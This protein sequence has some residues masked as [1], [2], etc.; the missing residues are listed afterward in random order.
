MD[1]MITK[2]FWIVFL[3][4]MSMYMAT[5]SSTTNLITVCDCTKPKTKGLIDL[6]IPPYCDHAHSYTHTKPENTKYTIVSKNRPPYYFRGYLCE[7]WIKE[8]KIIG[9]F[10]I[11][12]FNTEYQ[13]YS[14]EVS[15]DECWKMVTELKCGDASEPNMIQAVKGSNEAFKR[16]KEPDGPGKWF[17]EITY[18]ETNFEFRK[19]DLRQ[20]QNENQTFTKSFTLTDWFNT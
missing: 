7:K 4:Q 12:A 1:K 18:T 20:D 17:S 13:Q 15:R 14:K 10:W 5:Y 16:I 6:K 2:I 11:G 3:A 19:I 8:K 9:S